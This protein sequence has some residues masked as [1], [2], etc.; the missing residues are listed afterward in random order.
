MNG[1]LARREVRKGKACRFESA[2]LIFFMIFKGESRG[3]PAVL[4]AGGSVRPVGR[5]PCALRGLICNQAPVAGRCSAQ[6][7]SGGQRFRRWITTGNVPV[8]NTA[9]RA[10][11][12]IDNT[13][14]FEIFAQQKAQNRTRHRHL[15]GRGA[16]GAKRPRPPEAEVLAGQVVDHYA[17]FSGGGVGGEPEFAVAVSGRNRSGGCA[18]EFQRLHPETGRKRQLHIGFAFF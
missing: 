6:M 7:A 16:R 13:P 1:Y 17:A 11:K 8:R 4:K 3:K 5:R 10:D 15:A 2:G 12:L 18:V 9:D 14:G